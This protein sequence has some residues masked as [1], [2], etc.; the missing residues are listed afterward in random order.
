MRYPEA[1]QTRR[2]RQ[3]ASTA[4]SFKSLVLGMGAPRCLVMLECHRRGRRLSFEIGSA[5]L[6]LL[7][8]FPH[9][10]LGTKLTRRLS[11]PARKPKPCG[12]Q[13]LDYNWF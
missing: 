5:E 2:N 12:D 6:V 7:S 10:H 8:V 13:P 1:A 3:G 4:S 11:Y 9:G